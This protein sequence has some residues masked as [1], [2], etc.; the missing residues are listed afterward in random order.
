MRRHLSVTRVQVNNDE[1]QPNVTT[2]D[3]EVVRNDRGLLSWALTFVTADEPW[4]RGRGE[5][6][7]LV[8]VTGSRRLRGSA[9]LIRSD[10]GRWH[11]FQGAGKLDG[12]EP[13]EFE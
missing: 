5:C 2:G 9:A 7:L 1:L 4:H 13:S 11:Y 12:V 8:E 6:Q 3:L 10:G